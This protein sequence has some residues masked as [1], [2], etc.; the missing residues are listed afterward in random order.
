MNTESR[1]PPVIEAPP[2]VTNTA[3]ASPPAAGPAPRRKRRWWLYALVGF[4][5]AL[6]AGLAVVTGLALYWHSLVKNYTSTTPQE[7]PRVEGNPGD[8]EDLTAKFM[9]FKEMVD[10]GRASRPFQLSADDLNLLIANN[11]DLSGK[12]FLQMEGNELTGRFSIP[13]DQTKKKELKGRFLN[14]WARLTVDMDDGF[15][16]LKVAA[17]KVNNRNLPGWIAKKIQGKN[18]LDKMNDNPDTKNFL[19]GLQEVSIKDNLLTFTP[20]D[21]GR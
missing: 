7:I 4:G 1:Q 18:L 9:Q 3:P 20:L 5:G 10:I 13:L 2:I 8:L 19:Q 16:N 15:L 11:P 12:V 21:L 14:G 17:L 6:F